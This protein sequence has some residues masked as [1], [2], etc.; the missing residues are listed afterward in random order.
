[1]ACVLWD[2]LNL[3]ADEGEMRDELRSCATDDDLIRLAY[4]VLVELDLRSKRENNIRE[5]QQR[6]AAAIAG[7]PDARI[8]RDCRL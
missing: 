6:L 2:G 1:M 4:A 8:S 5:M 3:K 7:N